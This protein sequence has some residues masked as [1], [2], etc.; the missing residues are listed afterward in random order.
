MWNRCE[1]LIICG[2]SC[3]RFLFGRGNHSPREA[4]LSPM[5]RNRVPYRP[6]TGLRWVGE[7]FRSLEIPCTVF[8]FVSTVFVYF[9]C[10]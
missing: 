3:R 4:A 10:V 7:R 9:H 8:I 6:M 1:P 5:C 2:A